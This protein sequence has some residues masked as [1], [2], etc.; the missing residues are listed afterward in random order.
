MFT[1]RLSPASAALTIFWIMYGIT[2]AFALYQAMQDVN[3]DLFLI[4]AGTGALLV[5]AT[6]ALIW[7]DRAAPARTN[8]ELE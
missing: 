2:A 5:V 6:F 8:R 7:H 3:R 1:R 4:L